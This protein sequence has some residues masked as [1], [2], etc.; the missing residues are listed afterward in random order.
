MLKG[1][2]P[3]RMTEWLGI[4]YYTRG[5]YQASDR[6][7]VPAEQVKGL[8]EKTDIGWEIYPQGLTDLLVRVSNDYTGLPICVTKNGMAE[9]EGND[10]PR[11]VKYYEEHLKASYRAFQGLLHNTR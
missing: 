5:L 7:G 9:V 8:L 6:P 1:Q 2:Y 4:N 3:Q 11:R 10:D